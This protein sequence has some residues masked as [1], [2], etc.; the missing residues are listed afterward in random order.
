[1]ASTERR[2]A[3]TGDL[4]KQMAQDL[5]S[6]VRQEIDLAKAEVSEKGKQIGA[7]AGMFG[8]AGLIGLLAAM[9]LTAC[10]VLALSEL[11][12]PALAALTV[13][14]VYGIVAG[15][16]F[17]MGRGKFDEAAPPVPEQT[18]ESVKEDVEWL[19]HPTR[20]ESRSTTPA[21]G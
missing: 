15:V 19:K 1:M 3:S 7:G 21:R 14:V 9:A 20:S 12:H 2:D 16:M 11:M 5:G 17:L 13:A 4:L 6:L 8:G 10:F 18:V